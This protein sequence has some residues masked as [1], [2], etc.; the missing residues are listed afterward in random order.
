M[1]K[2]GANGSKKAFKAFKNAT[3]YCDCGG[4]YTTASYSGTFSNC[5]PQ[6]S[7]EKS[8]MHQKYLET[9]IKK[10]RALTETKKLE[11]KVQCPCGSV[12]KDN[13]YGIYQGAGKTSHENTKKHRK[14]VEKS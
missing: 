13:G 5:D 2:Y 12:Y 3:I 9:G 7:H 11:G 8:K 1:G 10:V 14:W 6:A 4:F